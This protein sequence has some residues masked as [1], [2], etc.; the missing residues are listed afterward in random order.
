MGHLWDALGGYSNGEEEMVLAARMVSVCMYISKLQWW[1]PNDV[2]HHTKQV[3][4]EVFLQEV[5][6]EMFQLDNIKW[7]GDTIEAAMI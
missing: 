2:L 1:E 3:N 5:S 6:V 7:E 4:V